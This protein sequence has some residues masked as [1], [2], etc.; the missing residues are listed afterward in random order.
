[1]NVDDA[2]DVLLEAEYSAFGE[3]SVLAGDGSALSVG[4]AGG[5]SDVDSGLTRFGARDYDARVGRWTAKDPIGFDGGQVNLF[6]YTNSDALNVADPE[7][8]YACAGAAAAGIGFTIYFLHKIYRD[9]FPDEPI[10]APPGPDSCPL[11]EPADDAQPPMC[12]GG[13][14]TGDSDESEHTKKARPSTKEKHE[15]GKRRKGRDRR[16]GE[17][18]DERRPYQR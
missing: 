8:T 17:K 13:D 12:G 5:E 6:R 9:L 16:G 11:P 4:F 1:V 2:T 10:P 7:G 15:K 14:G 3:R 18:G